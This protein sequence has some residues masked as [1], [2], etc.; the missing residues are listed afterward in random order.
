MLLRG[1]LRHCRLKSCVV[2]L[3]IFFCTADKGFDYS[4]P[5][6]NSYFASP[7][8]ATPTPR[9]SQIIDPMP[10][11]RRPAPAVRASLVNS[12]N[13]APMSDRTAARTTMT[14]TSQRPKSAGSLS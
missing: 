10:V 1:S 14:T 5:T 12:D 3:L 2:L 13:A 7:S 11:T 4:S 8:V 6:T 9:N